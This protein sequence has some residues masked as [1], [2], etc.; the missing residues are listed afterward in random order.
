MHTRDSR[1]NGDAYGVAHAQPDAAD[2]EPNA[3][4]ERKKEI[5]EDK[6]CRPTRVD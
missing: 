6:G 2:G 3:R 1:A 4:A 5:E